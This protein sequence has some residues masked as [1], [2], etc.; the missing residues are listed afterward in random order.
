VSFVEIF[1]QPFFQKGNLE[2]S[3][4]KTE[5][6]KSHFHFNFSLPPTK[7]DC[8]N[9]LS[10]IVTSI[11]RVGRRNFASS[12]SRGGGHGPEPPGSVGPALFTLD[13]RSS[14]SKYLFQNLPF[15]IENR[16]RLTAVMTLFTASGLSIPFFLLRHQLIK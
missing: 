2:K 5:T 4:I 10:R 11:G 15:Q 16:Y 1:A 7:S 13:T 3:G 14:C 9:M 6:K 12:A 8:T